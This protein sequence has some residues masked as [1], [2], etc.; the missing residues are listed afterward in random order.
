MKINYIET[1]GRRLTNGHSV[2][3]HHRNTAQLAIAFLEGY[4]WMKDSTTKEVTVYVV[5]PDSLADK[6]GNPQ[7]II[8]EVKEGERLFFEDHTKQHHGKISKN[9]STWFNI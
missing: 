3:F 7:K 5:T 4:D 1:S 6:D 2:Q 8:K 9:V